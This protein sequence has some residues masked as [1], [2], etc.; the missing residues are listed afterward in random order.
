MG[1]FGSEPVANARL[2]SDTHYPRSSPDV[3]NP[4]P[5]QSPSRTADMKRLENV[6]WMGRRSMSTGICNPSS[7]RYMVKIDGQ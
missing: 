5:F 7:A 4:K 1:L 3:A 6:V 2:T